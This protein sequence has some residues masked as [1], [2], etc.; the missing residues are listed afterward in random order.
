MACKK[1]KKRKIKR[2]RKLPI[3]KK[4]KRKLTGMSA[5]R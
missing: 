5:G 2:K 4:S 3:R 1:P